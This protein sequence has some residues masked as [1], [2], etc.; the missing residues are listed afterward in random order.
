M[1]ALSLLLALA[2]LTPV[3]A[4]S[5]D[6]NALIDPVIQGTERDVISKVMKTLDSEDRQN[7]IFVDKD[8]KVYANKVKLK[9]NLK[10]PKK[11]KDNLYE[12]EN[13]KQFA[14][15]ELS[16]RPTD[17]SGREVQGPTSAKVQLAAFLAQVTVNSGGTTGPYRRVYSR[18]GYS[19]ATGYVHL[20]GR[21]EIN[22]TIGTADAGHTYLGGWGSNGGAVDAG[23]QRQ[24]DSLYCR[25]GVWKIQR[26]WV[27]VRGE[28]RRVLEVLCI[29]G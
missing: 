27:A 16:P 3:H 21:T 9:L 29:F 24:L 28:P 22:E 15:P 1:A 20:A 4:Q 10:K 6:V 5:D 26:H 19:R 25:R 13:G 11:I 2:L 14:A 8:G 18:P 7:V 17:F 12:D 23:F